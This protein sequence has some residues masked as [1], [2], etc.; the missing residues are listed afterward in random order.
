M[1]LDVDDGI[2]LAHPD[3]FSK[4]ASMV[5]C[6]IAGSELI[7][8][9]CRPF[10]VSV[11]VVPTCVD[12]GRYPIREHRAASRPVIGWTGTSSNVG[13]LELIREA[14]EAVYKRQPFDLALV[15]D[16]AA[17]QR[18]PPVSGPEVRHLLWSA[19]T[20]GT[21]LLHFDVGVMPLPDDDWARFKCGLKLIQYMA[22]GLPAVAS[23]V[24]VNP[25]I[26]AHGETGFLAE[27]S[28][29]WVEFLSRLVS[30]H[31]LRARMGRAGRAVIESR[32]SIEANW[33][34]WKSAVL[35]AG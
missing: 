17:R 7:A 1:V 10:N 25:Q 16:G 15:A 19:A 4:I 6:V 14:L 24:G 12:P 35:G 18:L 27:S 29:A 11:A 3:K 28:D 23:P 2:F 13:F 33:R 26:V 20:E 9:E 31:E 21:D 34:G 5:D 22:A 32:Y 8:A 30:D